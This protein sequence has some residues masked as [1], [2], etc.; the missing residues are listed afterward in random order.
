MRKFKRIQAMFL[1]VILAVMSIGTT[2]TFAA[3]NTMSTNYAEE[4]VS[5]ASLTTI[6]NQTFN[7][8]GYHT[9]STRTYNYDGIG[10][11][12]TFKDQNGNALTDGSI[13]AV[14]LYTSSGQ[15]VKEW[16]SSNGMIVVASPTLKLTNGNRYYFQYLVAYGTQNMQINMH[17]YTS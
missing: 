1:A 6:V 14:R 9:G 12:C 13:L 15:L 10:F 4:T 8:N 5:P 16:Q 3:E 2:T 17:I 11:N 7:I